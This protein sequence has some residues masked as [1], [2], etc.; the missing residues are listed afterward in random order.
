MNNEDDLDH[1]AVG[2]SILVLQCWLTAVWA[3]GQEIFNCNNLTFDYIKH[4]Y[5]NIKSTETV[6]TTKNIVI[7]WKLNEM[8]RNWNILFSLIHDT[9][10]ARYLL[11]VLEIFSHC[12]L[13]DSHPATDSHH[14]S[15]AT[16]NRW[17]H[18][19]GASHGADTSTLLPC[20]IHF[21]H[22]H[23]KY[24]KQMFELRVQSTAEVV[25]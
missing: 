10:R 17:S 3:H 24:D 19:H 14:S 1:A 23:V 2:E 20:L 22:F 4:Y 11:I 5:H 21:C 18:S 25:N 9:D 13:V 12:V 7:Y 15:L 16:F 8:S 6:L